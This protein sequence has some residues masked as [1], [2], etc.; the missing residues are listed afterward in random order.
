MG[1]EVATPTDEPGLYR[2]NGILEVVG[3]AGA[4]EGAE[5]CLFAHGTMEFRA[6]PAASFVLWGIVA[7]PEDD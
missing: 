2:L 6:L 5:G 7:R 1:L 4:Y 3:G